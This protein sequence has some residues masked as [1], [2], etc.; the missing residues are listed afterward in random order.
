MHVNVDLIPK[1]PINML[2]LEIATKIAEAMY[3]GGTIYHKN[4]SSY[5]LSTAQE[6]ID[7]CNRE[8]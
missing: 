5:A 6:L 8:K 2:K 3:K 7:G 1:N 4:I